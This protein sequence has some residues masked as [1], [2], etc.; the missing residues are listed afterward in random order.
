MATLT[1]NPLSMRP[2]T[3]HQSVSIPPYQ[4]A[5][6]K[7]AAVKRAHSPESGRDDGQVQS[8][9]RLKPIPDEPGPSN[10]REEARREKERKR[11]E[12][13]EE[14]RIK[15]RRAFPNWVFYF[16]LDALGPDVATMRDT[17]ERRVL[18]MGARVDDFFSKDITHLVT[19]QTE[20]ADK[21][22]STKP[23]QPGLSLGSPIRLRGRMANELP[24]PASD[25]LTKKALAFGIK[26]WSSA[27]LENVLDRCY[28]PA[29]P[30][31]TA[32]RAVSVAPRGRT[33]SR[34][35]DHERVHGTTTERDP[36]EKRHDY[37][38]F[39][40]GS[41][42]VLIED[43]RQE[44]A[45]VAAFEYPPAKSRDGKEKPTWPV[46]YLD[47]RARGP[48]VPYDEKE[49]RQ[50]KKADRMDREREE[51]LAHRKAQL[52]Q[53]R[54][55][56]TQAMQQ[57]KQH[58]LRRSVSMSNLRRRASFHDAGVEGFVDLDADIGDAE[59]ANASGYLASGAYMA[60]S[61]NSVNITSATGTTSTAGHTIRSLHLPV[62]LR[63][64]LQQQI[65]TSR[66]FI[67]PTEGKENMMGPPPTIPT[68]IHAL[69][70][71][72]STN[73]MRLPKREEGMKPGY[74]ECCRVKFE[75]FRTHTEGR[76]HR[77]FATDDSNFVQ[78]DYLLQR[79]QRRTVEEVQ[80][81][82]RKWAS[83]FSLGAEVA[84]EDVVDDGNAHDPMSEDDVRWTEWVDDREV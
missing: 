31:R 14:F 44:L 7:P 34:L 62:G 83:R 25:H 72:R 4:P 75:D 13:E 21:E 16:D 78:L 12:R 45:T 38:Y 11:A 53:E 70:K 43:M 65:V 19:L 10:A 35:L 61:G 67:N 77:K 48:F 69:R 22:N 40:K 81:E 57:A 27:K 32:S 63:G 49:E 68:R 37:T 74:C 6:R 3:Q 46:L 51:E 84:Y 23:E 42:F 26:V 52:E 76:R 9:K 24:M 20:D 56:R 59:S 82:K 54:R 79:V 39:S 18:Y 30:S 55:R 58:D 64:R 2:H 60:A 17:L 80:E 41:C 5:G 29:A 71:S 47:H 73:T 36:T 66:R 28:A 1:R 33:L 15:Y 8:A 50:R